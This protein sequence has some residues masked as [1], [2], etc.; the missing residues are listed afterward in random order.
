L[1]RLAKEVKPYHPSKN[2]VAAACQGSKALSP[3]QES[4][5]SGL[6]RKYSL[7]AQGRIWL[8][9]LAKE[10]QPYHPSKN[11]IAAT[12]QGRKTL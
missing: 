6:P 10:V 7:I 1:Q 2:L 4:G 11:L 5:C 9:R 3:K 8:Q 12:C